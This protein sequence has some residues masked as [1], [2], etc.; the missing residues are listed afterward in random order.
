MYSII[1]P[2]RRAREKDGVLRNPMAKATPEG[3]H[4]AY[5]NPR[6]EACVLNAEIRANTTAEESMKIALFSGRLPSP[7]RS[8]NKMVRN[9]HTRGSRS[10]LARLSQTKAVG[11]GNV[12]PG[13]VYALLYRM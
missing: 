6:L 13:I 7:A 8:V 2:T 3:I 10:N 4:L 11:T 5:H 12:G 1:P 9:Y